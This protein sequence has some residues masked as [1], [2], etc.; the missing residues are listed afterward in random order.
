MAMAQPV[1][2]SR[3]KTNE[4]LYAEIGARALAMEEAAN[5]VGQPVVQGFARPSIPSLPELIAKGREVVTYWNKRLYTACCTEDPSEQVLRDE[6]GSIL[7][8]GD[9]VAVDAITG[10]LDKIPMMPTVVAK[11]IATVIV[12]SS[13]DQ[14]RKVSCDVW[15][16]FKP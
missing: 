2:E 3:A 9:T 1:G 16:G 6:I 13:F 4:D 7:G 5:G 10:A 14:G 12:N 11:A 15:K 8:A